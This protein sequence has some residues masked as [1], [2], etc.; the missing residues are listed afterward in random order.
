MPSNMP[1]FL[2]PHWLRDVRVVGRRRGAV[3][4]CRMLFLTL[5]G[6]EQGA[7]TDTWHIGQHHSD[8]MMVMMPPPN[9]PL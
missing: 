2:P 1:G 5:G 4:L 3:A 7:M 6:E 9:L 8:A